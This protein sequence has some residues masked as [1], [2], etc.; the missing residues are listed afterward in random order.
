MTARTTPAN[1]QRRAKNP[2]TPASLDDRSA[3]SEPRRS[4]TGRD[5]VKGARHRASA[6]DGS[7]ATRFGNVPSPEF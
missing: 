5:L 1:T 3:G 4:L 7:L 2:S 6:P